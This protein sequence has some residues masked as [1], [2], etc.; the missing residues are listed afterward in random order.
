[1]NFKDFDETL[2]TSN[3]LEVLNTCCPICGD[4]L[5]WTPC[6]KWSEE[7]TSWIF[8]GLAESCGVNYKYILLS[9]GTYSLGAE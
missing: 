8:Y 1:M 3:L 2:V 5:E 4:I 6:M 7:I 9:D